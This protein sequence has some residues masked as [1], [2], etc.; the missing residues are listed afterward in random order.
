VNSPVDFDLGGVVGVRLSGAGPREEAAVARQLGPI[1]GSLQ[2]EPDITLRFVE[3]LELSSPVRYIGLEEA[4]FTDD[5]FLVLRGKFKSRARVEI[6]F[7]RI[8]RP[9]ELRCERGLAAVP[10]LIPIVNLTALARGYL[11][12][13]AAA[14]VHSGV[15]VLATGWSKGGKTETLL[16]AMANGADYV[17]D[18]WVYL[19]PGGSE[20]FGIPEPI[21]VWSWHLDSLPAFRARLSRGE[22]ARLSLLRWMEGGMNR[23]T[24]GGARHGSAATRTLN[25]LSALMQGQQCVDLPPERLFGGARTNGS[26]PRGVRRA[27][28]DRVLLVVSHELSEITVRPIDP[29]EVAARMRHSLRE[30]GQRL[31]SAYNE[32]RFAFPRRRNELLERTAELHAARLDEALAGKRAYE[33]RHPYPVS[34]PELYRAIQPVLA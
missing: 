13:H 16:A 9:C 15:G 10:L 27:P 24:N 4:G 6:P 19:A 1:R 5:A 21:R 25:R 14:F 32:F 11:P 3:R 12:L 33:V 2:R 17:G 22:R 20:M 26:G 18:E 23:V 34:L 7:E 30:E 29:A 28:I 8:G 31:E